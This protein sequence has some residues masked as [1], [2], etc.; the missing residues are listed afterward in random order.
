MSM[1]ALKLFMFSIYFKMSLRV[2]KLSAFRNIL[3]L[4]K[5]GNGLRGFCS[6]VD[7]NIPQDKG[8]IKYIFF[9]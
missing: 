9:L 1:R 3:V 8:Y 6:Q 2:L 7:T 5:N 4:T